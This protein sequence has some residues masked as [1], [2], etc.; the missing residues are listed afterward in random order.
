VEERQV[1][2]EERQARVEERQVQVE[3]RQV[4]VEEWEVLKWLMICED[5]YVCGVVHGNAA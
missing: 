5:D 1:Q 4:Q 3:E 2:V